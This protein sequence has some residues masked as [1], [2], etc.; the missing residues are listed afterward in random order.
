MSVTL[1]FFKQAATN[2]L[3][4]ERKVGGAGGIGGGSKNVSLSVF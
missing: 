1:L 3:N 2:I 4:V